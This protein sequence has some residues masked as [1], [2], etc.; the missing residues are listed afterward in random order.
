MVWFVSKHVYPF[1]VSGLFNRLQDKV[2]GQHL[3]LKT[4]SRYINAHMTDPDPSKAVM[5]ALHGGTGT[6]KSYI[7]SI[8][9]ES[10][11]QKGMKSKFVHFVSSA[12]HF[13]NNKDV[14]QY[15]VSYSTLRFDLHFDNSLYIFPCIWVTANSMK[16][17]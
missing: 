7:T 9:A 2:Y 13:R 16:F 4:V 1:T 10:I 11:Y 6:G 17:S 5:L 12:I 8:I 3:V 15:K 14:E